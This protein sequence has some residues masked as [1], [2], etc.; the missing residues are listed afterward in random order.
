MIHVS[1]AAASSSLAVA[2]GG[3]T[4]GTLTT[5][6]SGNGTLS[7]AEASSAITTGTTITVGDL[8]GTFAQPPGPPKPPSPPAPPTP[9]LVAS[10]TD[11]S[12]AT[13]QGNFDSNRGEL[14]IHVSGA[15]ARSS[16]SVAV[17]GT[18]V[19]TL[20][21]DPSGNGALSITEATSAITTGTT[22]TVGDLSGAFAQPPAPP[23]LM[24]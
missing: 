12:G 7:I 24:P 1:G 22:I 4:V 8:S 15:A 21:T 14:M 19:G 3:T 6:A 13:G 2:V 18:T 9:P 10:L 23:K 20:T 5:D 17:G 11:S 16:L